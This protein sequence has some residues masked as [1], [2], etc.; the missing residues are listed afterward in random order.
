MP[1]VP[2]LEEQLGDR[3]SVKVIFWTSFILY[4]FIIPLKAGMFC[5][6]SFSDTFGLDVVL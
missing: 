2:S 3:V 4:W 1:A 5:I 6:K